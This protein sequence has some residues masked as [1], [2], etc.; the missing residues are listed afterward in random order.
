MAGIRGQRGLGDIVGVPPH[1]EMRDTPAHTTLHLPT[2]N[3]TCLLGTALPH[4]HT[5]RA[6]LPCHGIQWHTNYTSH[7]HSHSCKRLGQAYKAPTQ[8]HK[9]HPVD[10]LQ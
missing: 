4:C 7:H 9:D 3:Y 6:D 8:G 5:R 10:N 2:P 1:K